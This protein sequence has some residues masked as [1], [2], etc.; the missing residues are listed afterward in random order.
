[1]LKID[2]LF[3]KMLL[4]FVKIVKLNVQK[5]NGN[6][7]EYLKFKVVFNVE[8][9]KKEVYDVIEKFKFLLDFVEGSVK[10]CL[11]KFMLGLDKYEE[12][13]IVFQECF[14]WVDIVVLVVKKC[15]D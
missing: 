10:L 15:I 7:L 14:G 12:V 13:W 4:V 6:L 1:M 3:E 11:V 8:V 5:F 2:Q 9:D